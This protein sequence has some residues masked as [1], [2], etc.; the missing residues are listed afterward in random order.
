MS[1]PLPAGTA[2]KRKVPVLVGRRRLFASVKTRSR[3]HLEAPHPSGRGPATDRTRRLRR[4]GDGAPEMKA[5]RIGG[6]LK[7]IMCPEPAF[8]SK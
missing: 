7:R 3:R 1:S 2:S 5:A 8:E 6:I 4:R